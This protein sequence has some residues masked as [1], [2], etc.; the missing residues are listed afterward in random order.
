MADIKSPSDGAG[1][2]TADSP[3]RMPCVEDIQVPENLEAKIGNPLEGI[4]RNQLMQD[5]E[6]FAD[7]YGLQEHLA[8][9]KQGALVAQNPLGLRDIDGAERLSEEQIQVLEDEVNHKWRMP[10]KL[11]LTVATCSIGSAVA[12][13]DQTGSNGATIF[14]PQYYGIGSDSTHDTVLV[15]LINAGPYL[16]SAL[17][18]GIGIG[19]KFSTVPVYAAENAP[20][21]IRGALVMSWQFWVAFGIMLGTAVNLAVYKVQ[22]DRNWRLMLGLPC[23]PAVPLILLIYLCP[24]SPRWLM[25]RNRY[26]DAWASLRKLRFNDIQVARD[27]YYINAQLDIEHQIIGQTNFLQRGVQLFTVP[28]IRRANLAAF[29]V[30]LA[31]Q[32]CGINIIAFFSTT[33]FKQSGLSDFQAMIGSFGFGLTNWLFCFPA[34]WTIDTFGRRTLL[35][36]TFP[37]MFWTLLGA[38]LCTL[39]SEDA[40]N[41]RTGLICLFVFLF[42]AFYSPGEGP[43]PYAY[44]A[45]VYPLS[46]RE[47]GMAFAVATCL[48]WASVLGITLPF[49]LVKLGALGVFCFYAGLNLVALVMIFLWVPETMLRTLEELDWVFAVPVREFMRYQVFVVLPW[50][51]KRWILFQRDAVKAPLYH[52]EHVAANTEKVAASGTV[53]KKRV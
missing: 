17:V 47:M 37:H 51:V 16:S 27:I 46:H 7:K 13:W 21:A 38:G 26:A 33:I 28:R 50:F 41:V 45:E 2:G 23:I 8:V 25:K 5:V 24:E 10:W 52:F 53:E 9:L 35:L 1:T 15:G 20:A 14:F 44:S 11:F 48:G 12:G 4:S 22:G 31:Q 3:N 32:L 29:T 42:A 30:M 18:M 49:M 39:I 19:L 34:V 6:V 43:V 40:G 36:F